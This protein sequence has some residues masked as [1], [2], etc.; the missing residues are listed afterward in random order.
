VPV[1]AAIFYYD[2]GSPY[3]Y[4]AS[5]RLSEV[6]PTPADWRP[7]SLGALFKHNGRSSWSLDDPKRRRAGMEEVQRRAQRYGLPP[8]RWPEPWPSNYLI[9][10]RAATFATRAGQGQR[11]V[12]CTFRAAFQHGR[13]L[14]LIDEV[15]N[16]A[17]QAGLDP[18]AV[19]EAVQDPEIKLALRATTDEAHA[20]GVFGV[21]T[22]AVADELFWGDDRLED[23]AAQLSRGI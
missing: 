6:L 9:A 11:F 2:L 22:I 12:E 17:Q 16:A 10:M 23:A 4:L 15:L 13:D 3:A 14:G 20:S 19:R 21:P 7:V 5:E 8:V 1:P 18:D